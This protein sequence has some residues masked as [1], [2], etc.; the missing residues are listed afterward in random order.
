MMKQ[1]VVGTRIYFQKI[2]YGKFSNIY[3]LTIQDKDSKEAR[4][5]TKDELVAGKYPVGLQPRIVKHNL[6]FVPLMEV[7]HKP[8]RNYI[9]TNQQ[10]NIRLHQDYM[11]RNM[12]KTINATIYQHLKEKYLGKSRV[13]LDR[14][15]DAA[16]N[17]MK[18]KNSASFLNEIM[19]D[20][21]L[22]TGAVTETSGGAVATMPSTYDGNK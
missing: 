9:K 2:K 12:P 11:V 17:R 16:L 4:E 18:N 14:I 13:I 15:N 8:S 5:L 10:G 20:L 22:T 1:I 3:E 6:G 19:S 21:V 7:T